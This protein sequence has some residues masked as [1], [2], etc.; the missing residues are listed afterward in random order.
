[1]PALDEAACGALGARLAGARDARGL[2]VAQVS[3]ALLL[4]PRQVRAL[5]QVEPE[6]FH[7]TAF[8]LTALRKYVG[9]LGLPAD[10]LE[11]VVQAPVEPVTEP[12]DARVP[13]ITMRVM[14]TLF[15]N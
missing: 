7:S 11:G 9:Y 3:H 13:G 15:G 4:S 5:E 1:M 14:S 8:Y 12:A 2:S 10:L 6:A